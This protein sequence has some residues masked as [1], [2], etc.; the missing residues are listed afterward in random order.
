MAKRRRFNP[1]AMAAAMA[2]LQQLMQHRYQ[3]A[4]QENAARLQGERQEAQ[5]AFS[6]I[7]Q[8]ESGA[9]KLSN[10]S[11]NLL[12]QIGKYIDIPSVAQRGQDR[13]V[14]AVEGEIGDAKSLGD[15]PTPNALM[16][17]LR[18]AGVDLDPVFGNMRV[19]PPSE[20]GLT[21]EGT[22]PSTSMGPVIPETQKRVFETAQQK[23]NQLQNE[24]NKQLTGIETVDPSGA[25]TKTFKPTNQLGGQSFPT[26]LSAQRQGELDIEKTKAGPAFDKGIQDQLTATATSRAGSVER[27]Q[28]RERY[29]PWVIKQEID[30]AGQIAEIQA[31]KTNDIALMKEA[32]DATTQATTAIQPLY[33]MRELYNQIEDGGVTTQIGRTVGRATGQLQRFNPIA[34][35]LDQMREGMATMV[36]AALGGKGTVSDKDREAI[37]NV[38]PSSTTL[39]EVGDPLLNDLETTL[40]MAPIAAT[41]LPQMPIQQRLQTIQR[42]TQMLNSIP[43]ESQATGV[44]DP[45]TGV[46]LPRPGNAPTR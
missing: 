22:L 6:L 35:Q 19:D 18:G 28:V 46:F 37:L 13:A 1:A 3:L 32:R 20:D 33:A 41:H 39:H 9:L 30:K 43:P 27:A 4:G 2:P 31:R 25:T 44:V 45:T 8:V 10:M 5:N 7:P 42:W 36:Y 34:A 15:I 12:E 16:G 26:G 23:T 24:E 21:E 17:K 40:M 14:G 11:P 29:A 38:L